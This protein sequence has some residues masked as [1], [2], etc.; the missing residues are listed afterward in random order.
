MA[1][2]NAKKVKSTSS[3]KAKKTV[4]GPKRLSSASRQAQILKEL[5]SL[6]GKMGSGKASTSELAKVVGVTEPALY[7]HFENK[8]AML[9]SLLEF[10][11]GWSKEMDARGEA[12][13]LAVAKFLQDNPGVGRLVAGDGLCGEDQGL[14]LKADEFWQACVGA[15]GDADLGCGEAACEW[16]RGAMSKWL[17]GTRT[18]RIEES[19]SGRFAISRLCSRG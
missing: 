14:R 7:R 5:E 9:S 6:L 16:I 13:A 2:T 19:E 18:E 3:A 15:V 4:A 12:A 17:A 11:V 8:A 1:K 10:A